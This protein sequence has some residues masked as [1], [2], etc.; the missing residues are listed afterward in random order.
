MTLR[1]GVR[2]HKGAALTEIDVVE[3]REKYWKENWTQ[4]ALARLKRVTV[5]TIGKIVRG[6]T[7]QHVG[8][9][10]EVEIG[11]P[12]VRVPEEEIQASLA[13]LAALGISGETNESSEE[14]ADDE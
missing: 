13:R 5:N 2:L 3:I 11:H 9:A 7:W 1:D 4:G 8:E 12:P 14:K 10:E 6:E